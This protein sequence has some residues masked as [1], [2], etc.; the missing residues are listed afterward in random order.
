MASEKKKYRVKNL[1]DEEEIVTAELLTESVK[2]QYSVAE[3]GMYLVTH[4]DNTQTAFDK[5]SF[6]A[7]YEPVD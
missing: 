5:E 1:I 7:A 2:L 6:E 3:P 4:A